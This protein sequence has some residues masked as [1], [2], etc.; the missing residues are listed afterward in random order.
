MSGDAEAEQLRQLGQ[1]L[2]SDP[3]L[4]A[5]FAAKL[6]GEPIPPPAPFQQ[7]PTSEPMLPPTQQQFPPAP[8]QQVPE[9]LDL[10]DPQIKAL[11]DL[12][13][14]TRTEMQQ[15]AQ[16]L[17]QTRQASVAA[18]EA[19]AASLYRTAAEGFAQRYDLEQTDVDHL[20]N[21]AARLGV[22]TTLSQGID[23]LTGLPVRQDPIAAVDRALEIAYFTD[24]TYRQKEW[25]RQAKVRREDQ[26]RKQKLAAVQGSSGSAPRTT[27]APTTPDGMRGSML[28]EVRQMMSGEWSE[29]VAN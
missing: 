24:P 7:P 2:Q 15:Q 6:R 28:G 21:V 18:A 9:G 11:Y 27:P 25:E 10:E 22:L 20:S 14:S 16:T 1:L 29:P 4:R 8:A 19:Q 23:P 5:A 17:N 3:E 12:V 13:Q 26:Q